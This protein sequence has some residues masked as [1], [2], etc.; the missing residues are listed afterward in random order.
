MRTIEIDIVVTEDGT[1]TTAQ[2]VDLPQAST[3]P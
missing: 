3:A 1:L 2:T